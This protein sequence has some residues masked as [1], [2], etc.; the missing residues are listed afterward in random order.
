MWQAL[1]RF[2]GRTSGTPHPNSSLE[3]P[4]LPTWWIPRSINNTG[5]IVGWGHFCAVLWDRGKICRLPLLPGDD[6]SA[7]TD[8]NDRG[9]IVGYSRNPT[10]TT[11]AVLWED[12]TAIELCNLPAEV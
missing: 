1:T 2:L 11:R 6:H 9:Q 5:Q 3:D 12:G 8:I 7:A 4:G 10:G